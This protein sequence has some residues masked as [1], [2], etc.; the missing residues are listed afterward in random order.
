MESDPMEW[1]L[2][3]RVPVVTTAVPP[4]L[5]KVVAGIWLEPHVDLALGST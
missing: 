4:G 3:A 5:K 1:T 2:L